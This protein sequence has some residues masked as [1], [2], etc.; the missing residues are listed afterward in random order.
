MPDEK[1]ALLI[2]QLQGTQDALEQRLNTLEP[3]IDA[4]ISYMDTTKGGIGALITIAAA[5]GAVAGIVIEG[6]NYLTGK[7]G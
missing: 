3:K 6:L 5:G 1:F 4:L 7:H 2:G